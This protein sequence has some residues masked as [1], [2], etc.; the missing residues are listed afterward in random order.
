MTGKKLLYIDFFSLQ[1]TK[2]KKY[3][4]TDF[5]CVSSNWIPALQLLIC[6]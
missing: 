2:L 6:D 4:A 1:Y 5:L 3:L